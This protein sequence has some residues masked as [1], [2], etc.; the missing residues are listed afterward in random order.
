MAENEVEGKQSL[1]GMTEDEIKSK[2]SLVER[3]EDEVA[4]EP[5]VLI[6]DKAIQNTGRYF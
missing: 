5:T 3:I 6:R 4:G 2:V 1:A